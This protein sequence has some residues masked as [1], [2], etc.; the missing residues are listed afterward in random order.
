MSRRISD[1]FTKFEQFVKEY[2]I[3]NIPINRAQIEESKA[4]HK[5]LYGLMIFVAEFKVQN[6]MPVVSQ[7]FDETTSDLLLALFNWI[8]GMYKP[9][10]LE[11]RCSIEEFLKSILFISTPMVISMKSVYEIFDLAHKD[12]HFQTPFGATCLNQLK[13]DY[14]TLCATVHSAPVEIHSTS[15]LNFLPKYDGSLAKEVSKLFTKIIEIFLGVLFLNYADVVDKMHPE[16]KD[17]FL[18][19]LSKITKK[20]VV[21]SLY[22]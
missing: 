15:A 1:D 19:C 14:S 6:S 21:Q 5:K 22:C 12:K 10:K 13:S 18:C 3:Q 7:Y 16:N 2:S 9:A 20:K 11:L 17:D 4:M 8:Q